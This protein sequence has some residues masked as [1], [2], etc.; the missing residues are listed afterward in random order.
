[1]T[2]LREKH[3]EN[4]VGIG[5]NA[6]IKYFVLF[7][8]CSFSLEK[9]QKKRLTLFKTMNL[10][11]AKLKEFVYDNF[12]FDEK[13]SKREENDVGKGAIMRDFSCSHSVFRDLCSKHVKTRAWFGKGLC[14]E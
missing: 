1:M 12:E 10:G 13:F 14:F 9:K 3:F 8:Q 2:S 11:T 5:E 6:V 7:P 4:M